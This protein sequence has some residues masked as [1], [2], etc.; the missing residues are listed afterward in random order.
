MSDR[1]QE[2][3][4]KGKGKT[5]PVREVEAP[6]FQDNQYMKVVRFVIPR[7]RQPLP[8]GNTPGTHFC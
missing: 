4:G 5:I 3:K 2:D 1:F 7:H 6:R 8:S